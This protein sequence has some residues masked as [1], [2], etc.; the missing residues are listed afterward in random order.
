MKGHAFCKNHLARIASIVI[1][2]SPFC[3]TLLGTAIP[4]HAQN[5]DHPEDSCSVASLKGA[6]G[7]FRT[8][9]TSGGP[10]AAV[11]IVEFDGAGSSAARQTIRKNGITTSDLFNTPSMAGPYEV[12]PDC[13]GRILNPDGSDFAHFVVV[14]GGNEVFILSLS[15]AN[16]VYAVMKKI[17]RHR[18]G[19]E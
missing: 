7:F 2:T 15:D 6:Y 17:S 16:S 5:Q 4:A 8:G 10:L 19:R 11:G 1:L 14:N 12:D 3:G 9:T 13:A 18:E